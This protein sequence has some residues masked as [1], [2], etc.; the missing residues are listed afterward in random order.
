MNTI[1]TGCLLGYVLT[2]KNMLANSLGKPQKLEDD[3]FKWEWNVEV[4]G[5][6]V[7]IYGNG[8]GNSTHIWH[9]GTQETEK[10]ITKES[11][12]KIIA[13]VAKKCGWYGITKSEQKSLEEAFY[14]TDIDY[15]YKMNNN[16][17]VIR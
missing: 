1:S 5:I 4:D 17:I 14:L 7:T 2:T 9:I 12:D 8:S 6:V 10:K 13:K 16:P 15:I 11:F 3:K